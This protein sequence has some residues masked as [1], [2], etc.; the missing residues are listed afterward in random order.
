MLINMSIRMDS[1]V[2]CNSLSVGLFLSLFFSF[3]F[4][5][6]LCGFYGFDHVIM[7]LCECALHFVCTSC[8]GGGAVTVGV[9]SGGN[10]CVHIKFLFSYYWNIL[11]L[12]F[13]ALTLNVALLLNFYGTVFIELCYILIFAAPG[14]EACS[15]LRS[16]AAHKIRMRNACRSS[17]GKGTTRLVKGIS[18]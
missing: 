16:I 9:W 6:C 8:C 4:C 14:A 17:V 15:A 1:P 13:C 2:Q 7:W 18:R 11:L 12:I 5:H 10:C 3:L